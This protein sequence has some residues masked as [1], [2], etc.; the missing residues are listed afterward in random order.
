MSLNWKWNEKIGELIVE[1]ER[2]GEAHEYTISLYEGNAFL[3][4]LYEFTN[5]EGENLWN[6]WSFF[7][8]KEHAKICLGLKKNGQG[9]KKNIYVGG[10]DTFKKIRLNKA[11][12]RYW[13]DI[14][15]MFAQAFDNIDIEIFT[16]EGAAA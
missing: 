1:Q 4:M 10:F 5:E 2:D 16:E 15:P 7:T 6:M 12:S 11:K 14:V 3:I 8:D 9:E 13:K